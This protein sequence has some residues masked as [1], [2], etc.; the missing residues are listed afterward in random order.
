MCWLPVWTSKEEEAAVAFVDKTKQETP[1]KPK[2]GR[3][4]GRTKNQRQQTLLRDRLEKSKDPFDKVVAA[5]VLQTVSSD[6]GEEA[7]TDKAADQLGGPGSGPVVKSLKDVTPDM[8]DKAELG[9]LEVWAQLEAE[10]D[11]EVLPL[12]QARLEKLRP[13]PTPVSSPGGIVAEPP[14]EKPR[15]AEDLFQDSLKG[16]PLR[17]AIL[18]MYQGQPGLAQEVRDGYNSQNNPSLPEEL[19]VRLVDASLLWQD[20]DTYRISAGGQNGMVYNFYVHQSFGQ[21]VGEWHVHW[22]SGKKAGSPGWKRGKN[23]QKSGDYNEVRMRKLLGSWWA[24]VKGG[25]GARSL[26]GE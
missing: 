21:S 22:E 8:V 17:T 20:R 12:I 4:G 13:K 3:K 26:A 23:G 14:V 24:V 2:P 1:K 9:D 6:V 16:H 10:W 19:L 15:S 11:D 18:A 7:T 5:H 25:S